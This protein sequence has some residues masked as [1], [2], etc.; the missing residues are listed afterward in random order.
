MIISPQATLFLIIGGS[1]LFVASILRVFAW[2]MPWPYINDINEKNAGL[3]EFIFWMIAIW[4]SF[5]V[6][7]EN[8]Q[9]NINC[10]H[11]QSFHV[12]SVHTCRCSRRWQGWIRRRIIRTLLPSGRLSNGLHLP[13]ILLGL[14]LPILYGIQLEDLEQGIWQRGV[15]CAWHVRS[16]WGSRAQ[17]FEANWGSEASQV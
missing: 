16:Q 10:L 9:K 3:A 14:F 15:P 2:L 1:V 4:G 13:D 12:L 7:G 11:S 17:C 5:L 6:F 8:W